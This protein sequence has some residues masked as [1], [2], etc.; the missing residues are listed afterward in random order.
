[1][2]NCTVADGAQQLSTTVERFISAEKATMVIYYN[3]LHFISVGMGGINVVL[4]KNEQGRKRLCVLI[5]NYLCSC[6][7]LVLTTTCKCNTVR[8]G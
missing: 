5:Y 6:M 2:H 7:C 8:E 3:R 4:P 1:M